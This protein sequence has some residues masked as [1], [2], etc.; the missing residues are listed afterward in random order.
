MLLHVDGVASS[1]VRLFLDEVWRRLKV[2]GAWAA[3]C[4]VLPW[5]GTAAQLLEG[6]AALGSGSWPAE[7]VCVDDEDE[8]LLY[9]AVERLMGKSRHEIQ[10]Q[11]QQTMVGNFRGALNKTTPLQ[12]IGMVE[13]TDIAERSGISLREVEES[14]EVV[15]EAVE[16]TIPNDANG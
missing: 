2:N 6:L 11:I 5:P 10:E 8:T 9:A 12:A 4:G 7:R 15:E 14:E 3:R 13:S 1:F 16:K